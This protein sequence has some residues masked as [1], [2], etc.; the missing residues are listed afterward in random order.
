MVCVY[1]HRLHR[2]ANC[3]ESLFQ[4]HNG[5][6]GSNHDRTTFRAAKTLTCR[7][8]PLTTFTVRSPNTSGTSMAFPSYSSTNDL[9][10]L[11]EIGELMLGETNIQAAN[12]R[13]YRTVSLD[14]ETWS[15]RGV[16]LG[17][18]RLHRHTTF[19]PHQRIPNDARE[20]RPFPALACICHE[21]HSLL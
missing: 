11:R 17:N 12:S 3:F 9:V 1:I 15:Q 2:Y 4:S 20:L 19:C 5:S 18:N 7:S 10:L 13:Y 21:M 16:A 14:G 8:T 6:P